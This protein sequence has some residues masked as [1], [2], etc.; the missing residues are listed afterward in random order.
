LKVEVQT[1]QAS[2]KRLHIEIPAEQLQAELDR[3]LAT[4]QR[5]VEIPGFRR[6]RAPLAMVRA[7]YRDSAAA[8]VVQ[9][10]VPE[11]CQEAVAEHNLA[12]VGD[13]V[14]DPPLDSMTFVEGESL[15]FLLDV[16][17]K[18]PIQVP[19]YVTLEVD[20]RAPD[21]P[22]ADV[23]RWIASRR[24]ARGTFH[25]LEEDRP[26]AEGD[27]VYVDWDESRPGPEQSAAVR[28]EVRVVVGADGLPGGADRALIGMRV[29]ESKTVP[30]LRPSLSGPVDVHLVVRR[31]GSLAL[32]EVDDA[33]AAA[34]GYRNTEDMR[35]HV[36]DMLVRARKR[37]HR[38]AQRAS[39]IEQLIAKTDFEVPESVR[40]ERQRELAG[41]FIAEQGRAGERRD[42]GSLEAMV[43]AAREAAERQIR[44]EWLF[45]AIAERE[46]IT[47][48][49]ADVTERVREAAGRQGED[50]AQAE[51]RLRE[52][53]GWE[54][55]RRDIRD[56]RVLDLL[57][58]EASE[59]RTLIL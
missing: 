19:P 9:S 37:A 16:D 50:A 49:D 55:L 12:L 51:A 1:L 17:V 25:P 3:R 33:F 56:A 52:T 30:V 40:R 59:A 43:D 47:A 6:N 21:V 15:R 54:A 2:R 36:W 7:R 42:F 57:L 24:R 58:E 38:D 46:D 14:L 27:A 39:L 41:R 29:G 32:P 53:G 44:A 11:A 45:D 48:S 26:V 10:L 20:K 18:P 28:E 8:D 23:D 13:V 4:L 34:E 31:I 35:G 5:T 22:A